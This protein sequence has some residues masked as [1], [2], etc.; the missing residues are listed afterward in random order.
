MGRRKR[1][2][3]NGTTAVAEPP[4]ERNGT[5]TEP[6]DAKTR[7]EAKFSARSDRGTRIE[8]ACWAYRQSNGKGEEWVQYGITCSRSW[9]NDKTGEWHNDSGIYRIH[10]MPVLLYLL[11]RAYAYCLGKRT[12]VKVDGETVTDDTI[13]F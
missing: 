2:E 3:A 9:R 11:Q 13:P 1:E 8:V 4:A 7:P 10:D 12:E 5:A 6:A